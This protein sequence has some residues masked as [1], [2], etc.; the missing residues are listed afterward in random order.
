[1]GNERAESGW[2]NRHV[3]RIRNLK[4]SIIK[5]QNIGQDIKG[6][7]VSGPIKYDSRGFFQNQDG[8]IISIKNRKNRI[9]KLKSKI[10]A[11]RR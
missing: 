7:N 9:Q 2:S 10:K 11:N 6:L 1:M 8:K 3:N 4:S 5:N